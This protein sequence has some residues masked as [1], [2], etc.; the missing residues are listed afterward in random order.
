MSRPDGGAAFPTAQPHNTNATECEWLP[1]GGL[2]VRDWFAGQAPECPED[3]DWRGEPRPEPPAVRVAPLT[4]YD[5]QTTRRV[6]H[7][8]QYAKQIPGSPHWRT[9][10]R[11]ATQ[12]EIEAERVFN[13]TCATI[14][15]RN[16]LGRIVAWRYAYADA[17]LAAREA[18]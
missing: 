1:G 7:A 14:A 5:G 10:H 16:L 11:D 13:A 8:V 2:S 9:M 3:F 4:V 18:E 6:E 15:Q 12:S 17:M